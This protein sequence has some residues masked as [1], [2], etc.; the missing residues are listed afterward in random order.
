MGGRYVRR[1]RTV[2]RIIR[3]RRAAA[4]LPEPSSYWNDPRSRTR[5]H[6]RY[7]RHLSAEDPDARL[8]RVL[9]EGDRSPA[10]R[11]SGENRPRWAA[12]SNK[13]TDRNRQDRGDPGMAVAA[14]ARAGPGRHAAA[15][16]L[17][18]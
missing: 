17:R 18:A 9:R 13:R 2:L 7:P 12:I 10:V 15:A 4:E 8:R 5:R 3:Q 1:H 16:G 14:A 6:P 11:L